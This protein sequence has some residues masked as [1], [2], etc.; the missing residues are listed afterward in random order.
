MAGGKLWEELTGKKKSKLGNNKKIG[1]VAMLLLFFSIIISSVFTVY[2][3]DQI[4]IISCLLVFLLLIPVE[5]ILVQ[6]AQYILGKFIKPKKIPK[7]DFEKG[8]PEEYATFVVIPTI[9]NSKEKVEKLMKKLESYYIANKSENIY[10]ALLGDCTAGKNEKEPFDEEVIKVG[11]K[12]VKE[13]NAK[14]QGTVKLNEKYKNTLELD[15]KYQSEF[16]KFHFLYRKRTWNPKEECYLGWERKR[17]L[18]N[19]FNDYILGKTKNEFLENTIERFCK[20]KLENKTKS[21]YSN[22][23]EDDLEN[24][25]N[26][27]I[28]HSNYQENIQNNAKEI[29]N[30]IPRIKYVITLDADTVLTLNT[31]LE[32]IGAMAHILNKPVLNDKKDLVIEG[33]GILQPRVG[34]SLLEV[35]KSLFT[36]IYAGSGG[37]DAYT[38]AISDVYQD[39]FDEGIFTGKGIYD[40]K[41]FSDVLSGEIPENTV[42]SHDLLEGSYLRCG[43]AS[44]IMLMDG[45]PVGYNSFKA[46]LHRWI[47]GDW[48]IL[49]WLGNKIVNKREEKKHNPINLLSKYKILDNLI[50]SL[51]ESFIVISLI[52]ISILDLI[53]K[54]K[55]WPI[56]LLLL[57]SLLMPNILEIVNRIIFKK[58]EEKP[59]KMFTKT[60]AGVRSSIVRGFLALAS[61][62]DKAYFSLNAC[63]KTIY[64]MTVS[65]KNFL[66]WMTAEEAEKNAKKD[67]KSYY[68]NMMAN[69][70]LGILGY[71]LL[72][73]VDQNWCNIFIFLISS[74]WLIAPL[75]FCYISKEIKVPNK[76]DELTD[77]EKNYL[78]EVGK[79]TWQYFKENMTEKTH[80]LPPDNYQED[81]IPVVITRTS[82]TNIGLALL[83]TISSYDLKYETLENTIFLL[84][85]MIDSISSL[86][87]WNGHLYNWYQLEDLT[88][89]TPRYVSSVD[90]GN[91]IGYLYTTKQF[92]E[93]SIKQMQE[94]VENESNKKQEKPKSENKEQSEQR[95]IENNAEIIIQKIKTMISKIEK[96]I[97]E[98]D[99]SK[100]YDKETGLFSIG[101]NVE[102]SKLTDSYYDLLAS[103]ARQASLIAIAKRDIPAKHWN[104]LSRTLTILN[105]YKGLISWSGTA[106]EYLMPNANIPS[107]PGSLLDESVKFMLMSQR[108]YTKKLNVPWGISGSA[109]NLKD[110]NN[111][112][113][114][115][116]F[117][118][119]WLGLKRGLS[120]EVVVSSYGSIM[121]LPEAPKQ[122]LKNLKNLE[123]H[124]MYE[125]YGFYES[126]DY[127][128]TRLK[129][130]EKYAV[131]KTYMAHHQGLILLAINNLFSNNIFQKRF[132]QNPEL[133]AIDILL[134]E[135]MPENVILTKEEKEKVEKIKYV[136]DMDY[137]EREITKINSKLPQINSLSGNEYLIITDAKGE[138]YSKYKDLNITRYKKNAD[139]DQGIL[140]FF[141][142]VKTKKIWTSNKSSFLEEPEK[143]Q[144]LFAPS[145]NKIVRLDEDIE[146]TIKTTIAPNE[147]IELKTIELTNHSSDA[148]TIEVTSYLE[149]I[150]S[151]EAQDNSHPAFNNLFLN[152]EYLENEEAILVTRRKR[153]ISEKPIFV[154]VSMHAESGMIGELEYEIDKEKFWGRNLRTVPK[155]VQNSSPLSRQIQYTTDPIISFKRVIE[156]LPEKSL[157]LNFILAVG[158]SK[159]E[160]VNRLN[161]LTNSETIKHQFELS[162]AK[163]EAEN[164][165][166]GVNG[167]ELE[168]YQKILGYLYMQNPLKK[169]QYPSVNNV[170]VSKLWKY[171]I[172]GDLPILLVKIKEA[173][174]ID[175]VEEMLKL[176]HYFHLKNIKIDFVIINEEKYSYQNHLKDRIFNSILNE[177]I[178]YMQNQKAGI[179]VL[180]NLKPDEIYY[181]ECRA[182]LSIDSSY[183]NAKRYLKELEEEYLDTVKEMPKDENY[184]VVE[185]NPIRQKLENLKY[186]NEYG[187]FSEDGKEYLIRVNKDEK[188]PTV[189]SH[190]LTNENFGTLVTEGM[191][192]YTWYKNSRLNRLTSWNNMP[193]TDVPSEIIYLQDEENKKI[194]SLG[195]SPCPDEND[196]YVT[197]GFGYAKYNHTSKGLAQK[198]D[199]F[200]PT[201]DNIKVQILQL[202]NNDLKKK[203]IKLM[204]YIKPVLGEDEIKNNG[205]LK[206]DFYENSNL[207]CMRNVAEEKP[208]EGIVFVSSNEKIV[209]YTGSK[210]SFVG[211]GNLKN[212]DAMHQIALDKQNGLWQD[213]IIAMHI[214]VELEALETKKV[215][216]TFGVG[217]SVIDCQDLSYKYNN[218]GKVYEEY[219]KTKRFWKEKTEKLQVKTP[220]ESNNILLNGWLI[221]QVMASR[222]WGKTGYYQS[223]GA[224]GFRDQLQD[225]IAL[226][227]VDT[228]LMK[229]QIIKH[230]AHQFIEGDVEHWWHEDTVRGIRTRFSDDRLWLVYI[231]EDYLEFTGDKS[232][233]EIEVPYLQGEALEKGV[234]EKYDYYPE[235][236][237]KESI[238]EHCKKAID[239]SLDFGENGLPKIGSGDWNDGF[240]EVG[241]LRKRRKRMAWIFHLRYFGKVGAYLQGKIRKN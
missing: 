116:A 141:K 123:K 9:I 43:L 45:Y 233:L 110:L 216:L 63:I 20:G 195:V 15:E 192:G 75:I 147:P 118:I 175:V 179:F 66:E 178:S 200:V 32:L 189:W 126:I 2:L 186:Y 89:L 222:M 7:L 198:L 219:E 122:V 132:M 214:E 140:F 237:I 23:I 211:K 133:Q 39:N 6:I 10:F 102:E 156:I 105:K 62:P 169:M 241:N 228:N 173:E 185:E 148:Q 12:E 199:V 210:E 206:L 30:K 96:I 21:D 64:R 134:Q 1:I 11:L 154:G 164:R 239:I 91:L 73:F 212:P 223:G 44:D 51:H 130:G 38:N 74:L 138:G 104:N 13:L 193:V 18:L 82:P 145:Q 127:T 65:K 170:P 86:Q 125:K 8:V 36:K 165:Y 35:G 217:N 143:F 71:V 29:Q 58:E 78:L 155:A 167:K 203:K 72:F 85:K 180:E 163:A 152:Y 48:Q 119:P 88:P 92:L 196:Y 187:G 55:I 56:V 114:Y 205:Y 70:V 226:K 46:R 49:M 26:E 240:S 208:F 90:S 42:L 94:N 124:G 153:S 215:I 67:V 168:L 37:K 19:Q 162:K 171:G 174:D 128:P 190:L 84:E 41:V 47:R 87:K 194:W 234:D 17:G 129:K 33:H 69:V 207:I 106:F 101:F 93:N 209:S 182:N 150:L 98:T 22:I 183:G 201:E 139:V 238:Y 115:K 100:L 54:I 166:L 236:E 220:L 24:I 97:S 108:E 25:S 136:E 158:N 231:L 79:R 81:R 131:V 31:G 235:S 184:E 57:A 181:L 113:Q 137:Q 149:P 53:F 120:D 121:A 146:T 227:Y 157:S 204:Y 224:Y 160:V 213:G 144:T 177:N 27:E 218:M 111:N 83:A 232:I 172:S 107:Y 225:S 229:N 176:Y 112:Y 95:V 61:L 99:F 142:N 159:E 109:F 191:G 188:L 59:Q 80:F 52:Y 28:Q 76:L 103:E 4:G 16:P 5:V 161:S 40:V 117:G 50:R 14:Y 60:I 197:Y 68:K 3:Y 135:R 202:E 77:E 34:V 221:Y 230:S 151:T